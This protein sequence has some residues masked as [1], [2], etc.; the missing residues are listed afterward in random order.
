MKRTIF[1][2]NMI[3]MVEKHMIQAMTQN[4]IIKSILNYKKHQEKNNIKMT[5]FARLYT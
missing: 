3:Q 4:F 1:F 2:P 5:L